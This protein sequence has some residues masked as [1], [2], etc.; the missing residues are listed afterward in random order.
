MID[1]DKIKFLGGFGSVLVILSFLPYIGFILALI[2]FFLI[3]IAFKQISELKQEE[4]MFKDFL[5]GTI[6]GFVAIL[7]M[8]LGFKIV[9]SVFSIPDSPLLSK[10]FSVILYMSGWGLLIISA[11]FLKKIYF[12]LSK[13]FSTDAFKKAGELIYIGA[14]LSIIPFFAVIILIGFLFAAVGFF[15]IRT[16]STQINSN[17]LEL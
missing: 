1:V 6:I 13:V 16:V 3:G 8:L 15:S 17:I 2:G 14:V 10:I 12:Y 9:V 5:L 4:Y 11:N 7:I